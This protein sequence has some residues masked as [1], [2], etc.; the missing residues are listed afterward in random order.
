MAITLATVY[1]AG[2]YMGAAHW[3]PAFWAGALLVTHWIAFEV[4]VRHWVPSPGAVQPSTTLAW[5][6]G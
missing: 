5:V 6:E 4:L 2:P 1:D 3:I